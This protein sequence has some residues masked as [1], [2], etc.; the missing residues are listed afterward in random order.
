MPALICVSLQ[1][2]YWTYDN[3]IAKRARKLVSVAL[4]QFISETDGIRERGEGSKGGEGGSMS[5][6]GGVD[7]RGGGEGV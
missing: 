3:I 6:G 7:E 5:E 1:M 2:H 4:Y